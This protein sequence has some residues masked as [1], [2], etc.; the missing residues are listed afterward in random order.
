MPRSKHFF[1]ISFENT[2][3]IK[4]DL[5]FISVLFQ[6]YSIGCE[7]YRSDWWCR[8][9]YGRCDYVNEVRE[10]CRRTCDDPYYCGNSYL[11]YYCSN[12]ELI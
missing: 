6:Y 5:S 2:T 8:D 3:L 4:K 9:N 12:V 11:Y 1:H 10:N 7:N